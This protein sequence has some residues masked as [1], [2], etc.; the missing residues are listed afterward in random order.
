MAGMQAMPA[1]A[2]S[3]KFDVPEGELRTSLPEF[4][5]QAG[6]Q[7]IV[8]GEGTER[9]HTPKIKGEMD[10][11]RALAVFLQGTGIRIASDDGHTISLAAP[12]VKPAGRGPV[13]RGSRQEAAE[14][15]REAAPV[16]RANVSVPTPAAADGKNATTLDGLVVTGSRLNHAVFESPV[17]MM[18]MTGQEM[19]DHSYTDLA[20]ALSDLPGVAIGDTLAG[21][22]NSIQNSGTSTINLRNLGQNRTLTLINGKRTVSN[23]GNRNVVNLS[24]IPTFFISGVEVTTGGAS[25][26]Y[27]SDAIA[28]VVNIR[29][30]DSFDGIRLRAKKFGTDEGGGGR[31]E[32]SFLAGH[33]YF[34]DRLDVLLTGTYE[35]QE[36]LKATDRDWATESIAYNQ[37]SNTVTVPDKSSYTQG[38]RYGAAAYYF[39]FDKDNQLRRGFDT[40]RDGDDTRLYGT[41]ITPR[42]SSSAALKSTWHF[43]ESLKLVGQLMYSGIETRVYRNP[44]AYGYADTYGLKDEYTIG[45]MN[46]DNPYLLAWPE[47]RATVTSAGLLWRRR[48]NELGEEREVY[49][50][51]ETTRGWLGLEGTGEVWDWDVGYGYGAFEQNQKSYGGINLQNLSY[52]L[53]A[54][55]LNGQIVCVNAQARANG[56]VPINLFGYNSITKEMAD[57]IRHDAWLTTKNRQ[58][59]LQ[60]NVTGSPFELP[61]GPL[62]MAYG[63]EYRRDQSTVK[64]DQMTETGLVSWASVPRF[65]DSISVKEGYFEAVV[66]LAI[67]H[68]FARRWSV[69]AAVR[70]GNYDLDN[71][72][73]TLSW[74]MG[75]QWEPVRSVGFRTTYSRAQRAPDVSEVY[76]P[77]RDS[78]ANVSDICS[79][80]TATSTGAVSANCRANPGIAAAIAADGVF[81]QSTTYVNNPYS[82]NRELSEETADTFTAGVVLS[83]AAIPDMS[84]SVDYY[85]IKI[86]DVITSYSAATILNSCYTSAD[87]IV[88]NPYCDYVR[89]SDE[90]QLV[91]VLHELQNMDRMSA[92]GVDVAF[93]YG[94]NLQKLGVPGAFDL[95]VNYGRRLKLETR[96]MGLHG[97]ETESMLGEVDG[98]RHEARARLSWKHDRLSLYWTAR[99]IGS[100]VDSNERRAQIAEAGIQNPL[101]FNIPSF[102][103][104]DV[105]FSFRPKGSG[106]R[107]FGTVGNVFNK[108]GPFMPSGTDS[109]TGNF[110][111]LYPYGPWGRTFEIGLEVD[112]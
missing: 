57:Y 63:F 73:T 91:T 43:N 71:V 89:R 46:R 77:A 30:R 76:S 99:Y 109:A 96:Y 112:I 104:N 84:L 50:K 37:A 60:V 100:V 48:F 26:V 106:I 41:L 38:G 66:P 86:R 17:P 11:R 42:D 14:D 94:F 59:T 55:T 80:V 88:G 64:A 103:R 54:T 3:V 40:A 111:Y 90:G 68:P 67:D 47:I 74:R 107:I 15:V 32:L 92:R 29:T 24:T 93:A 6:L 51:R 62:Q 16:P 35:K 36:R 102:T 31:Q 49:N 21:N 56:C 8:P 101:Y 23:A 10:A 5:R 61:A 69:D 12:S 58:D 27:G 82:G 79:G 44:L 108:H 39:Y 34:D 18:V 110:N 87:G 98:A 22:Q 25:A 20:D 7:I 53:N 85:D 28:G 81:K 70:V 97:M 72:G 75:M 52:A 1:W 4:A 13:N 83:P 65:S 78:Y 9:L 33:S 95:D 45:R 2:Q 19:A 105:G